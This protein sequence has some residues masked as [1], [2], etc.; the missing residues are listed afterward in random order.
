MRIPRSLG[1]PAP[2]ISATSVLVR[3][4][5]SGIVLLEKDADAVLPVAS[6]AKL[7][8]A[9]VA[10]K[11]VDLDGVVEIQAQDVRV[12]PDRVGLKPGEKIL[13]RDLVKAML[14]ASANDA[15]MALASYAG[16]GVENFVA[17]MNAEAARLDM[18]DTVFIN[19]VGFDDK[20]QHSSAQDLSKLVQEFL[21][22][23]ELVA[24]AGIRQETVASVDKK[25]QHR[26][27][28]TNRLLGTHPEIVGLKTGYTT[29]ARGNLIILAREPGA[30]Y[31]ILLG[32]DDREGE[33]EKIFNW[34]KDNFVWR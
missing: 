15:A 8:T 17:A 26:L 7:M 29:E 13:A 22:Y 31:S 12:S 4:F 33:T 32:S 25:Y 5:S 3:D 21:N 9:I 14:I 16:G 18:R 27:E 19:P 34:V 11:R 28:T 6:L 30:W 20:D 24:I 1:R 10:A 23:P 2:A